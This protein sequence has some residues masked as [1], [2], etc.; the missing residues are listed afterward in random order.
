MNAGNLIKFCEN[1]SYWLDSVCGEMNA[2]V[3]VHIA[4]APCFIAIIED[5]HY[6]DYERNYQ[7]FALV[8]ALRKPIRILVNKQVKI[9]DEIITDY[10]DL[11]I[12][13]YKNRNDVDFKQTIREF[14]NG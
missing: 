14:L 10:D 8:R 2:I 13:R 6:F 1:Q 3:D 7:I 12:K 11:I 9:P 5:V 4:C